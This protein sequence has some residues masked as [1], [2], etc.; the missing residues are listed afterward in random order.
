MRRAGCTNRCDCSARKEQ[1][2]VETESTYVARVELLSQPSVQTHDTYG[3]GPRVVKETRRSSR[4]VGVS[5]KL[6]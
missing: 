5:G 3:G 4:A 1:S 6:T 2:D